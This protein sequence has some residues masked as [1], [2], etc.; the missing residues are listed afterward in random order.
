[1]AKLLN[2]RTEQQQLKEKQNA[3]KTLHDEFAETDA[4]ELS[5]DE[6]EQAT[7]GISGSQTEFPRTGL[8]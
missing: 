7:G 1:M 3:S 5:D 2:K 8:L 4:I 6:L